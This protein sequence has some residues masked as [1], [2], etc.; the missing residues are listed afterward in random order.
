MKRK[1]MLFTLAVTLASCKTVETTIDHSN[2]ATTPPIT[3]TTIPSTTPTT[4]PATS[5]KDW[6]AQSDDIA[7]QY[8]RSYSTLYPELGSSLG[9]QEY[10]KQGMNMT[11][12]F[13]D[14]GI[15]LQK[16]WQKKLK[17][18]LLHTTDKN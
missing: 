3:P 6:V 16:G 2:Q 4:T 15:A 8:T 13:K 7:E 5:T 10:D 17:K 14:K 12:D 9:Y 1:I 11:R 18:L